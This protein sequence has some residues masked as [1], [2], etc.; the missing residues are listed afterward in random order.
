MAVEVRQRRRVEEE[1]R[2]MASELEK[3]VDQRTEDLRHANAAMNFENA[4]RQYAQ[5]GLARSNEDLRQF[6]GFVSHE[7]RQPLSTIG[8]WA[9]L[10]ETSEPSLNDE[11]S[12]S[13]GKIRAAVSRMARL[14]E[15]ELALAQ[16]TQGEAPKETVDLEKLVTDVCTDM[17]P[18]LQD[19]RARVETGP[20][21]RVTADPQQ[22]RLM[23]RNLIEN[24]VKYRRDGQPPVVHV[25]ER[26]PDDAE[27]CEI[28]V[29]DNGRGFDP[30]D[31]DR[32]FAIFRRADEGEVHGA[33]GSA[34]R[35][36]HI[37]KTPFSL[38]NF[39]RIGLQRVC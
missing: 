38:R 19:A 28:V 22:L 21:G 39:C 36:P 26:N 20:L 3:R 9:E 11:Q 16:V 31:A 29:R 37:L 7:L 18:I 32:L 25:A 30:A 8:I 10:L 4:L 14:I 5:E 24:A 27:V 12:C 35:C 33:G 1:L 23:I 13:V 6:A 2:G 15:G 34:G 17:A